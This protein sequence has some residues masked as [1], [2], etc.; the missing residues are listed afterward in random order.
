MKA[1]TVSAPATDVWSSSTPVCQITGISSNEPQ[2]AG[3]WRHRAGLADHRT[4]H[5]QV[6]GGSEW[7]GYGPDLLPASDVYRSAGQRDGW[8]N[9]RRCAA[10]SREWIR[11]EAVGWGMLY[12]FHPAGTSSSAL[13]AE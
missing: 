12:L 4:A 5:D 7:N 11:H 1:V 6:A 3:G 10:Q 13:V 9:H 8:R 2:R